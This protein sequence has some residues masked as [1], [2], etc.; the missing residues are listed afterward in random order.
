MAGTFVLVKNEKRLPRVASCRFCCCL[1]SIIYCLLLRSCL[2]AARRALHCSSRSPSRAGASAR[3]G[4]TAPNAHAWKCQPHARVA[5]FVAKGRSHKGVCLIRGKRIQISSGYEDQEEAKK[6]VR[7]SSTEL[8]DEGPQT[9]GRGSY[10]LNANLVSC[11]KP[12]SGAGSRKATYVQMPP[13]C[14]PAHEHGARP[15]PPCPVSPKQTK[16]LL[17]PEVCSIWFWGRRGLLIH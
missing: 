8:T 6:C 13:G 16:P 9:A 5:K 7:R 12:G 10:L 4:V 17:P 3:R 15:S 11:W 1:L 2:G 14:T